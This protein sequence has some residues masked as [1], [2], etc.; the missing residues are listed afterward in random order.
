M[1]QNGVMDV[2]SRLG[3]EPAINGS[4]A[5][6]V[7]PGWPA[8]GAGVELTTSDSQGFK[9]VSICDTPPVMAEGIKTLVAS[10]S[11]LPF[12][13]TTDSLR[14]ALEH[15]RRDSPGVLLMDKA[16]GI[17]ALLDWLGELR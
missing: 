1:G 2:N 3:A 14:G 5:N 13:A 9:T 11:E 17:Q 10:R 4:I 6:P 15:L 16:F 8:A 7:L 12:L